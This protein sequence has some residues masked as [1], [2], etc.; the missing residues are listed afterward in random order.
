LQS[1]D[2]ARTLATASALQARFTMQTVIFACFGE[3]NLDAIVYPSGN[4]PPGILTSP[5]EPTCQRSRLVLVGNQQPGVSRD[6]GARRASR[7]LSMTGVQAARCCRRFPLRYRSGSS[8]SRCPSMSPYSSRSRG[9]TNQR[10][11]IE[12]HLRNSGRFELMMD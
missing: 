3:M 2:N 1:S 4:I 5:A 12:G 10:R 9:R 7:R 6:N 8:F 11:T